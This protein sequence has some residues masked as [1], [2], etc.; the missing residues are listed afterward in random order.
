MSTN[1]EKFVVSLGF[2]TQD[3]KQLKS[4]LK[5]QE[6]SSKLAKK[7]QAETQSALKKENALKRK[8]L[9]MEKLI[10]K[11]R[12]QGL[13]VKFYER[14]LRS[15][16]KLE[17]IEKR[18]LDL[19]KAILNHQKKQ[20][21][22]V[23]KQ[24]SAQKKGAGVRVSDRGQAGAAS[25]DFKAALGSLTGKTRQQ[26]E[27]AEYYKGLLKNE[28]FAKLREQYVRQQGLRANS[29]GASDAYVK[30]IRDQARA[31][32]G[33]R[34]AMQKL[35]NDLREHAIVQRK[36]RMQ[37]HKHNLAMQGLNDSARH[38]IRSYVSVFAVLAGTTAINTVGQKFEAMQSAM[39]AATGTAELAASEIAFLDDM[40]S[41]LGLSLLDVSDAYTKFLFA[42]KGKLDQSETRELFEGLSEL[43][44]TLGVSKERMKLSMNAISQMMNKGKI[45]SEELKLQL[46]ESLPGELLVT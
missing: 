37:V 19:E 32:Y 13:D 41:R 35:N 6:Q 39:L 11:A 26:S 3:L 17:T 29:M 12:K 40:T 42:S 28:E 20:T 10:E 15:A 31:A 8:Q 25:R 2:N 45:S 27:M 14:S 9:Q 24:A 30:S 16:K 7:T 21:S 38:M 43:G 5:M 22:E 4:L 1:V 34:S 44:T 46:A 33:T 18:R 36:A 23:N